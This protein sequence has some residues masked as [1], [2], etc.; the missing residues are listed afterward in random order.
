VHRKLEEIARNQNAALPV[1]V[2]A[3]TRMDRVEV[4]S[5]EDEL[6]Y[7]YTI[8]LPREEFASMRPRLEDQLT[9]VYCKQMVDF[10]Q[11]DVRAKWQYRDQA[12][13]MIFEIS[14]NPASCDA[15]AREP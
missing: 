9:K 4:T 8:L 1:F 3:K 13:V 2:D 6:V 14:R 10:V 5:W 11:N 15:N 12:N 7:Q